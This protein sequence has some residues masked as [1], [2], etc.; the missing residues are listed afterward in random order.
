M[1]LQ[2]LFTRQINDL[3]RFMRAQG[4]PLRA[5]Q[6]PSD[7][8][9]M[10]MKVLTRLDDDPQFPHVMLGAKLAFL[11][12][13]QFF[14]AL[15]G[16]VQ[17][18]LA[19]ARDQLKDA[20]VQIRLPSETDS[21]TRARDRFINTFSRIADQLPRPVRSMVLVLD[22]E[23]VQDQEG[24]LEAMAWLADN[25]P[26]RRAKYLV[27]DDGSGPSLTNLAER[28]R[29]ASVGQFDIKPQQIEA[30][31]HADMANPALLSE[32]EQRQNLALLAGFAFSKRQH[33]EALRLHG[34]FLTMLPEQE[35]DGPE[36]ASAL[37]NLGNVH[38]AKGDGSA[39]EAHYAHALE[40]CM[41]KK[42]D[43]I[44]PMVLSNM[45]LA[46][47]RQG[48]AEEA[49][50]CFEIARRSSQVQ[51]HPLL[52]AH[53]LDNLAGIYQ[54]ESRFPEAERCLMDALAL[55]QGIKSEFFAD[56]RK[57]GQADVEA[58]LVRHRAMAGRQ[59]DQSA[60]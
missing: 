32:L 38:L 35:R 30:Q 21:L 10:V 25:T 20:G 56:M 4:Q 27:F 49:I 52:E 51:R 15:H 33:D 7:L 48:R 44:M 1:P 26:S 16:V 41:A 29:G 22:P 36:A 17:T 59:P 60:S 19:R 14:S 3:R 8:K 31:I 28:C 13:H 6:L 55:Y 50:K 24:Y 2:D 34:Q 39:A 12:E 18:E 58:K 11:D 46:V 37:Y 23:K 57:S 54:A 40:I 9:P 47:H 53:V 45:G 42:L 43:G 5:L